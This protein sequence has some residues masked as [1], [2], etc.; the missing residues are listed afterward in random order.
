[1]AWL[2]T[3]QFSCSRRVGRSLPAIPLLFEFLNPTDVATSVPLGHV[4][5]HQVEDLA[6]LHHRQLHLRPREALG[7]IS[8]ETGLS[9]VDPGDEVFVFRLVGAR[10]QEGPFHN[11]QRGIATALGHHAGECDVL[12]FLGHR[13]GRRGDCNIDGGTR[14]CRSKV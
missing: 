6:L 13:G 1:M 5:D 8:V 12:A 4:Q 10:R 3:S 7:V 9:H 11:G 2:L 14:I